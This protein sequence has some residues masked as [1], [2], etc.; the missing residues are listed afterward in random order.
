MVTQ[1]FDPAHGET[2]VAAGA[3][4]PSVSVQAETYAS[5]KCHLW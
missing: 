4:Y 1:L 5:V 2:R 3:I